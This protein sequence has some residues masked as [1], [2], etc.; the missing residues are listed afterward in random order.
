MQGT[1]RFRSSFTFMEGNVP[2]M[3]VQCKVVNINLVN[4][5]VDVTSQFDR[6]RY[7]DIQVG[8]P[9]MHYSNGEGLSIFPEVGA[10]C[11]VCLPSDSS[12]PYVSAFIMPVEITDMAAPDAPKGTTSKG[13]PGA[14]S[15][16][17][18]FAGG[19]PRAKPGDMWLRTRDDNFVILH[20]GGV[21]QLGA[22]ELAQRIYIPL[23]QIIMDISQNYVHHN[24]G[25]A[26]FWGLQDGPGV[27]N[28]PTEYGHIFRVFANDKAADIRVKFG[29]VSDPIPEPAGD[30]G[31]Q[32]DIDLLGLGAGD[33][34]IVAEVVVAP[35][36]FNPETGSAINPDVRNQTVFRFFFDR[37]GGT[38]L[39]CE[40][41]LLVSTKKRLHIRATEGIDVKTDKEFAL[42]AKTGATVDGGAF[43]HI[44]G[45]VVRLGPGAKPVAVQGGL[46]QVS[47]P[48]T[49]IPIPGSPPLV[50]FGTIITGEPTVLA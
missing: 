7:F 18:S 48:Y 6:K 5:T 10:K 36:G 34:F 30:A 15:S 16:G 25:G 49:P 44:K 8:S 23:N 38:F 47:F 2:A 4:W 21:L 3:M 12:P 45:G 27:E 31:N 35:G 29:K 19:R 17:A 40:G 13:S 41:N 37:A 1:T 42:T 20:R 22:S 32:G 43:A 26:I 39:R 33:N 11:M 46:V 9:Y 24:S 14:T 28:I 50:L